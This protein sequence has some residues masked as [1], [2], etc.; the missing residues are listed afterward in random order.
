M[1]S[2]TSSFSIPCPYTHPGGLY[3]EFQLP[4]FSWLKELAKPLMNFASQ[5]QDFK[6]WPRYPAN[7]PGFTVTSNDAV[8]PAQP[9]T[10]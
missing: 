1:Y 3:T 6:H 8:V 9:K 7:I 4:D 2:D 10:P 5:S